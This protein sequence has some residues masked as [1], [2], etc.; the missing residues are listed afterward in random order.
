MGNI[1]RQLVDLISQCEAVKKISDD[2]IGEKQAMGNINQRHIHPNSKLETQIKPG[3]FHRTKKAQNKRTVIPLS[4][5]LFKIKEEFIKRITAKE[6]MKK[7][8]LQPSP[9]K[10]QKL[11]KVCFQSD[12]ST[13][14]QILK[15]RCVLETNFIS[16]ESEGYISRIRDL[17][18]YKV[19]LI[20]CGC[21]NITYLSI[22]SLEVIF[23]SNEHENIRK[24]NKGFKPGWLQGEVIAAYFYCLRQRYKN[25]FSLTQVKH[26]LRA[27]SDQSDVCCPI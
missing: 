19:S 4:I 24:I 8:E 23:T 15:K 27:C 5:T 20:K 10:K 3:K 11:S 18:D 25:F 17:K 22:L 7:P 9:C 16:K 26:S 6:P 2:D 12:K 21:I 1:D 14:K 13:K